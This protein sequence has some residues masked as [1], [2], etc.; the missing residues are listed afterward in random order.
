MLD[1]DN[2]HSYQIK[3]A[4]FITERLFCGL[5]LDMGLGKT[6]T[7]LTAISDLLDDFL[8]TRVLII[9]PLRVANTVW[10][11]EAKNWDHLKH[12]NI[13]IC[14]GSIKDRTKAIQSNADIIVINRENVPWLVEKFKWSFDMIVIDESSSFKSH[15]SKRFRALKKVRKHCN[16]L[17]ILTGTPSPNSLI[18]LWAQIYLLDFGQ[19]I[20]RTI[21]NFRSRFC[22]S[23]GFKGYGWAIK[24]S[25]SRQQ[26]KD[27]ISDICM[28]MSAKD[29][30]SLPDRIDVTRY[31][32]LDNDAQAVYNEMEKELIILLEG[33]TSIIA[34]TAAQ[35]VNKLFQICNGAIYDEDKNAHHIHDFK[36]DSL[37]ELVEDN[38]DENLLVAYNFKSDLDRLRKAFPNAVTLSSSGDELDLWNKGKI[39]MLLAHPASAGH[40]LN[41]QFG[42]NVI[43]WFGLT[44]SLELYQQ[45]NARLH[46]Q[47]QM[48]PVR[49]VH[50]VAKGCLD[51]RVMQALSDKEA[52]QTD[53]LNYLKDQ[54]IVT[55]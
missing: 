41:A 44:W 54:L 13:E 31:C 14:T 5:F 30:L 33:G 3:A 46:R 45:F 17:V 4:R 49:I 39:K 32:E 6:V 15:K 8:T 47:G 12:L 55:K 26:I 23:A 9:A 42:G 36:I 48:K 37:K 11:Q 19:R 18:D 34:D 40:G 28:S 7:T 21:G 22:K 38:P 10:K 20:G 29:Y 53:L 43:V 16:S 24:D 25:E 52:D 51:E 35:V 50:L 27:K 1:R 2:L